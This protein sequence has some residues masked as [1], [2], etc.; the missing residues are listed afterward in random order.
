MVFSVRDRFG[1]LRPLRS[2]SSASDCGEFLRMISS[3]SRFFA[4]TLREKPRAAGDHS[5]EFAAIACRTGGAKR[6]QEAQSVSYAED[7]G[8]LRLGEGVATEPAAHSQGRLPARS[9]CHGA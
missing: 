2:A 6:T 8:A 9:G 7:H 5:Q 3:S 4:D 1:F